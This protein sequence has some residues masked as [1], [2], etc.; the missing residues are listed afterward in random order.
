MQRKILNEAHELYDEFFHI[1]RRGSARPSEAE[2]LQQD[3]CSAVRTTPVEHSVLL[4]TTPELLSKLIFTSNPAPSASNT[5]K[6][7]RVTHYQELC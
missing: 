2:S 7:N 6:M 1:A 5:N 3:A 4:T